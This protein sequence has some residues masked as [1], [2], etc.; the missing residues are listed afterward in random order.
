MMDAKEAILLDK[1]LS[2]KVG[3]AAWVKARLQRMDKNCRQS[4]LAQNNRD[5]L[6]WLDSIIEDTGGYPAATPEVA[7]QN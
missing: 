3:M 2:V 4:E 7:D 6:H 1:L 5:L